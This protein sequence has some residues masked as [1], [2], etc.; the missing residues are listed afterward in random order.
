MQSKIK[1][2]TIL[3]AEDDQIISRVIKM[4]LSSEG[5]KVV[6]FQNGEKV[7][8]QVKLVKPDLILLDNMMPVKDGLTILKEI[9]NIPEIS[10]IPIIFLTSLSDRNSVTK[11]LED[12]AADY[13]LKPYTNEDLLLRIR[14]QLQKKS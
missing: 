11:C 7:V 4:K 10:K 8:E 6:H 3:Y 9:K 13:I 14:K 5:F 1:K 2:Y 12:G